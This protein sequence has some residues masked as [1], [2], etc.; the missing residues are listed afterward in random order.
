MSEESRLTQAKV[1]R[2]QQGAK[3]ARAA[4]AD[5]R[6]PPG[7]KR[8]E[9]FPVLDLGVL[10]SLAADAWRVRVHGLVA[11]EL[12]LD[13]PALLALPQVTAVSDFHCV[14]QWS[15]LDLD[16]EGV[17]A[18]TLLALSE[19]LPDARHVTLHGADGYTTNLPLAALSDG[20]VLLAHRVLGQPLSR[21]HGGPLR[22]VVPKRYGWK[23]AKWLVAVE[24]HAQ[25]RPGFWE[26]RGYHNEADPWREQRYASDD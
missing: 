2:A 8:V 17:P 7:Q 15:R 25:D 1:R 26:V 12:N 10:P 4:G 13:L 11:N 18:A 24:L 16:W 19:P 6:M 3:P 20:D 23:S 5:A 22:L 21:E 14:T 9:D